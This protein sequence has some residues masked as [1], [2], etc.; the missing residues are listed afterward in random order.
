VATL[1]LLL[2]ASTIAFAEPQQVEEVEKTFRPKA[3][4]PLIAEVKGDGGEFRLTSPERL[5]EVRARYRYDTEHFS[6]IL[7]WDAER[8]RFR[9][10][11]DMDGMHFDSDDGDHPS[12]LS[13]VVPRGTPV[14][15]DVDLKAGVVDIEG[16]G[17]DF[18]SIALRL[19]AGELTADFPDPS[20][21]PIQRMTVDVKMGETTLRGLGNLTFD[22]LD[23]NGF[24]GEMTV[25]LTGAVR[26]R[27]RVLID[28]EMGEVTVDVPK[29][30]AVEARISKLGFLA[31]VDLPA[32]WSREG[33]YAY[34]PGTRDG[35]PELRLDIRGGIGQITIRER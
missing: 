3:G 22:E 35:M 32:G 24:A 16:E 12:E 30:M 14:D 23:I 27:R 6:G 31:E 11:L 25:D 21:R 5:N 17:L 29:G 13:L 33:R 34:S 28:L 7:D 19:W 2:A 4:V 20:K 10:D 8:N 9:A 1:L 15:L 26:M 18:T